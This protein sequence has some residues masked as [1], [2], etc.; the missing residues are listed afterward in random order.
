MRS[1]KELLE[2]MLENQN[3]F[4]TGLCLW[5]RYLLDKHVITISEYD[6]LDCYIKKNRPFILSS[7][8]AFNHRNRTFYW[9][10]G[11]IKYRINWIKKHI[12]K[13]V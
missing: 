11:E 13:Q 8:S 12:N 5:A 7:L 10:N 9:D 4:Q 1:I 3:L 2:V 6:C